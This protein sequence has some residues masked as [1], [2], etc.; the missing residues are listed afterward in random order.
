VSGSDSNK[1]VKLETV[2]NLSMALII[3]IGDGACRA[4]NHIYLTNNIDGIDFLAI[5]TDKQALCR[6]DIPIERQL[7][8][9]MNVTNGLGSGFNPEV[10]RESA[11]ES[12]SAIKEIV[13]KD[14]KIVFILAGMGGVTGIGSSPIIAR[15]CRD[16]GCVVVTIVSV[17]SVFEGNIRKTISRNGIDLL[18]KSSDM[19]LLFSNDRIA[20]SHCNVNNPEVFK[21]SDLV[22]KMPV[23]FIIRMITSKEYPLID[24]DDLKTVVQGS[25]VLLTAI[26]GLGDGEDRVTEALLKL[27]SSP[28]LLGVDIKAVNNILLFIESGSENQIRMSDIGIII[29][30]LQEKFG[31][32]AVIVWG[33]GINA[34]FS[35]EIRLN[36]LL[37]GEFLDRF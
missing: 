16:I 19:V 21:F 25:N 35:T 2:T 14:Y 15:L 11:L 6:L 9:G 10:G 18:Y 20:S 3:G 5:N 7:L 30:N 8:I 28:Y 24:F 31:E 22:F 37:T 23:D 4:L 36:A 27:Y 34:N 17:P 13:S 32:N 26:S 1:M 29:D 33:C 12:I